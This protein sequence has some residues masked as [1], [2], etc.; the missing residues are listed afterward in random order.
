MELE[1]NFDPT[2][3]GESCPIIFNPHLNIG[4]FGKKINTIVD[5]KY[6]CY[7]SKNKKTIFEKIK[8][9]NIKEKITVIKVL[10][11]NNQGGNLKSGTIYVGTDN[12][13]YLIYHDGK[14]NKFDNLN[15]SITIIKLDGSGIAYVTNN[16][17]KVYH[18]NL[19]G[20]CS[21]K[22]EGIESS[23]LEKE[24]KLYYDN[25]K[26]EKFVENNWYNNPNNKLVFKTFN[27]LK[28]D[29]T[30]DYKK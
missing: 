12:G 22:L 6:R 4:S 27:V 23:D 8:N 15:F 10:D 29:P 11:K 28:S 14:C 1:T 17:E 30:D 24:L 26:L 21:E 16:Q 20:W 5:Y 13:V 3:L 25:N 2:V 19:V 9:S 7:L 18:L